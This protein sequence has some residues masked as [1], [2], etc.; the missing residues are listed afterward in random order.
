M[1]SKPEI[2]RIKEIYKKEGFNVF[3][4]FTNDEY[5]IVDFKQLFNLWNI[6]KVDYEYKLLDVSELHKVKIIN[7]TMSW[8]NVSIPLL[9]ENGIEKQFPFELDPIV[10]YQN[11]CIDNDKILEK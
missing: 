2:V 5:R 6:T 11:S 10:L 9:D 4:H 3:C 8:N 7:G 1:K